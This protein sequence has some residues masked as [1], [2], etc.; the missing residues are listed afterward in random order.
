MRLKN[1]LILAAAATLFVAATAFADKASEE[2]AQQV[3]PWSINALPEFSTPL[4]D[5]NETEPAN[6]ACPGE[7]YTLGDVYH[8][9]ITTGD[10]DWVTFSATAGHLLTLGTDQDGADAVDT[11]I[12]LY[13][14]D[15]TTLLTSNDDGGPGLYSLI[16]DFPA[17]YTG[18]YALK[19]RPFGSA[20]GGYFFIGVSEIPPIHSVCPLDGYK[21]LKL[22]SNVP[23]PDNDPT[24][25]TV[26]PLQFF[27]DGTVILD[28]IV[29]L[30]IDHTWVGDLI[31]RLTHIDGGGNVRT[32]DLIQ[33]P[34]V[35]A[36]TYGCSGNLVGTQTDKYYFATNG[37][38]EEM[39]ESSCPIDIPVYCYQVA[40]ENP[41]GL[42]QWRGLPKDGQ[43][44]LTVS[45][46]AG[47]DVGTLWDFSLHVLNEQPVS[48]ES[49]SWGS[50][51]ASYR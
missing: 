27:P 22:G 31:V 8:G 39:G 42:V 49:A 26:G 47:G 38:L 23:I 51:K 33:R 29:D 50:V 36:S 9:T 19:I 46:H 40:P 20:T 17:P 43:W 16:S 18:N 1:H 3:K 24:G 30:G 10:L 2:A 41:N 48:V 44:F 35:P 4:A 14:D 32:V 6:N 34:G 21:G 5:V 7:A 11:V 25:V 13:A 45:D 15:C 12:E 37:N 28:L